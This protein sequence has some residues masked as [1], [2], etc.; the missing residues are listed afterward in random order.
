[1]FNN[2]KKERSFITVT[3]TRID[4]IRLGM[5][6]KLLKKCFLRVGLKLSQVIRIECILSN[7]IK[8]AFLIRQEL[9]YQLINKRY[10]SIIFTR[11]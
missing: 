8:T 11:L 2:E 4:L 6:L 7:L 9:S 10:M 5:P 3:K 1:M